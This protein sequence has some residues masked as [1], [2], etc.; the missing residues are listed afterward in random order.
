MIL[1]KDLLCQQ[2]HKY[3]CCNSWNSGLGKSLRMVISL[4]MEVHWNKLQIGP[5]MTPLN[6]LN[7]GFRVYEVDSAVSRILP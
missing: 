5:S 6:N 3:E 2:W 1:L 4:E 7:S